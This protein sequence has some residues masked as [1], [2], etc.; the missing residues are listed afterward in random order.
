MSWLTWQVVALV[1][2]AVATVFLWRAQAIWDWKR[3]VEARMDLHGEAIRALQGLVEGLRKSQLLADNVIAEEHQAMC[4]AIAR[5][6]QTES[7]LA[8][9]VLREGEAAKIIR[10]NNAAIAKELDELRTR[11]S[12]IEAP[13]MYGMGVVR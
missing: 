3:S 2:I 8:D 5:L 4:T 1:G 10:E 6:V 11:L 7:T 9:V 12:R 13:A